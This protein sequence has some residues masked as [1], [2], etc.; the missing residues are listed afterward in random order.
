M[1]YAD[2]CYPCFVV[3]FLLGTRDIVIF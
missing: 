2:P 3:F 1:G